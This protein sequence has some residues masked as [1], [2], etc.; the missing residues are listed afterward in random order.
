[1]ERFKQ[2]IFDLENKVDEIEKKLEKTFQGD[3]EKRNSIHYVGF[4]KEQGE[5]Q[6]D[7]YDTFR[8]IQFKNIDFVGNETGHMQNRTVYC[9]LNPTLSIKEICEIDTRNNFYTIFIDFAG[10]IDDL[11][12]E[13]TTFDIYQTDIIKDKSQGYTKYYGGNPRLSVQRKLPQNK[14]REVK[15]ELSSRIFEICDDTFGK[16]T[17]RISFKN[18]YTIC[19]HVQTYITPFENVNISHQIKS[20]TKKYVEW[21]FIYGKN[22]SEVSKNACFHWFV[23]GNIEAKKVD[24]LLS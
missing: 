10:N 15:K 17:I 11:E 16:T 8:F 3:T 4:E 14:A 20:I 23:Q 7:E 12:N 1:M 5:I 9:L 6:L 2:K 13:N 24:D 21:E 18:Q 22:G 19:P